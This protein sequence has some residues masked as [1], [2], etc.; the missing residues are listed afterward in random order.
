M[1]NKENKAITNKHSHNSIKVW[2]E[3]CQYNNFKAL[4]A[5]YYG[6]P[7]NLKKADWICYL[8][9]RYYNCV[10]TV[11]LKLTEVKL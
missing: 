9:A 6:R 3:P 5:A 11:L 8:L 7:E 10:G 1:L 4:V 2:M